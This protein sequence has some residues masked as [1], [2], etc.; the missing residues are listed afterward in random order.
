MLLELLQ[1][2]VRRVAATYGGEYATACPFCGGRDRF[3]VWPHKHNGKGRWWCRQCGKTGDTADMLIALGKARDFREACA[4]LGRDTCSNPISASPVKRERKEFALP[5]Q[6]WRARAEIFIAWSHEKIKHE[7]LRLRQTRGIKPETAMKYKLGWNPTDWQRPRKPWGLPPRPDG[8]DTVW[9]P[10]GWVIPAS[11]DGMVHRVRIR[12]NA[13]RQDAPY[14]AIEGSNG[15]PMLVR[16]GLRTV[17]V[18]SELDG[19]LLAQELPSV[20]GVVAL[21]S[22][23][24][25]PDTDLIKKLKATSEEII[26]ALDADK[27]GEAAAEWWLQVLDHPAVRRLQPRGGKDPGEMFRNGFSLVQWVQ[28]ASTH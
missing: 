12:R 11:R 2:P 26:V 20:Y 19:I 14:V 8:R 13:G 7:L 22:A 3:R 27:T 4:I 5:N 25:R 24:V 18:E 21:G 16:S 10:S 23:W 17:V 15:A 9:I 1:T 6:T 28:T